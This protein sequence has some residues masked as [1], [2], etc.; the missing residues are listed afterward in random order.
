MKSV[1]IRVALAVILLGLVL[2][3][4][5][6]ESVPSS[7]IV[8]PVSYDPLNAGIGSPGAIVDEAQQATEN[9]AFFA[10]VKTDWPLL[11]IAEPRTAWEYVQRGMYRQDDLED[12][13]SAIEDYLHAEELLEEIAER[14]GDESLPERMLLIHLR[15][16]PIYL[17][18]G[19]WEDAIRHFEFVLEENPE[20]AGIQREIALAHHGMGKDQFQ[21]G[22]LSEAQESFRKAFESFEAELEVSPANQLTLYDFGEFLLDPEVR[23]DGIDQPARARTLFQ[24]YLERA[25]KHCDTYPIRILKVDKKAR[26]LGGAG[27]DLAIENCV[28]GKAVR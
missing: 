25:E 24:S 14:T 27:S 3:V 21:E 11:G 10:L 28:E 20:S 5:L 2:G 12:E 18:R 8:V 1:V 9:P 13:E 26:N 15:L 6:Y 19:E 4:V 7:A 16:G 23:L 17:H 22:L